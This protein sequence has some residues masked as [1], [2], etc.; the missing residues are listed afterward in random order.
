MP[1]NPKVT[2]NHFFKGRDLRWNRAHVLLI[3][4]LV[5]GAGAGSQGAKVAVH[6]EGGKSGQCDAH[7]VSHGRSGHG[8]LPLSVSRLCQETTQKKKRNKKKVEKMKTSF[9][10]DAFKLLL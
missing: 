4:L 3:H 8:K 5:T 2:Q 6:G 1:D 7:A 9:F 10:A